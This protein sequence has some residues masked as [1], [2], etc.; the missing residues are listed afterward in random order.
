MS[1]NPFGLGNLGAVI[2]RAFGNVFADIWIVAL[3]TLV[4]IVNPYV[5]SML[6]GTGLLSGMGGTI[7]SNFVNVLK[8]Q[9]FME[10]KDK[11]NDPGMAVLWGGLLG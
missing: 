5:S 2:T 1:S 7:Y 10:W 9:L 4:D 3:H 8:L 6:N 11:F